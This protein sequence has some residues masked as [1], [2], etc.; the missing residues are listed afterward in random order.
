MPD[1]DDGTDELLT[2]HAFDAE[3]FQALRARV[4]EGTRTPPVPEPRPPAPGDLRRLPPEGSA[5]LAALRARGRE[6]LAAGRVGVVVLAGG[7]ATRFG[8][9]VKGTVPVL[10]ERTFLDLRAEDVAAA[11]EEVKRPLSM[12]LMTSFATDQ[13]VREW[14]AAQ[15]DSRVSLGTFSQNIALRLT[16]DGELFRD[17]DGQVSPYAP[18][19]G[20][21]FEA[22]A[23]S[24]LLE[25]FRESGG[26]ILWLSNVDNLGATVDPAVLGVHLDGGHPVTV[27]VVDK[28]PGDKGGAPAWVDGR[29]QIVETFRFPPDFDQ[30]RIPVFNTN[31]L[32]LDLTL[33][34]APPALDWFQVKKTV[35][36]RP[37]LQLERLVG[38]VTARVDSTFLRVP[39]DGAASRFL[40]TK[41]WDDLESIR[42]LV[43]QRYGSSD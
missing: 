3:R 24:G 8:G 27:E 19:H 9:V 38:Q 29:L 10:G 6:A 5:E 33:F 12:F 13:G 1:W 40:P 37:A 2:R 43:V 23:A 18:G 15:D 41:T 31:T 32:L 22:F 16:E 28:H 30:D 14:A 21:L 20:D 25:A 11:A 42:P 39:R 7:M 26:E 4:R 36:G 35:D 34:D 17:A